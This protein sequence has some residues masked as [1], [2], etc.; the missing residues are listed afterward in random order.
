MKIKGLED[1]IV[2][3]TE[4]QNKLQD[5]VRYQKTHKEMQET[6]CK[7]LKEEKDITNELYDELKDQYIG[8]KELHDKKHKILFDI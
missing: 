3:C 4:V 6:K 2:F 1:Y 7:R 5:E 8:I